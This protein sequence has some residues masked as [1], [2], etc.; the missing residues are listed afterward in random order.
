MSPEIARKVVLFFHQRQAA[1]AGATAEIEA[2]T[3]R[4]TKILSQLA[5]GSLCKKI[6]HHMKTSA[7]TD[8][9][10]LQQIYNKLQVHSRQEAVMKFLD[11]QTG[12][13]GQTPA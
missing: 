3:T 13:S 8:R 1:A 5:K 10:R 7:D 12:P 6:A 11:R 2:L 9:T 4:E